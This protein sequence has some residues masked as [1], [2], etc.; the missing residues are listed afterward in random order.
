MN[1]AEEPTTP[2]NLKQREPEQTASSVG[3]NNPKAELQLSTD[4]AST[5]TTITSKLGGFDLSSDDVTSD[6]EPTTPPPSFSLSKQGPELRSATKDFSYS[7]DVSFMEPDVSEDYEEI[8]ET[9]S[10]SS[11]FTSLGI[12]TERVVHKG[13]DHHRMKDFAKAPKVNEEIDEAKGS[14]TQEG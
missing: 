8:D 10:S 7:T 11:L 14:S 3:S 9:I 13:K 12:D 2:P 5:I 6:E 1:M 4:D